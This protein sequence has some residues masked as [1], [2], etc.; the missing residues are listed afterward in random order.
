MRGA[1][2]DKYEPLEA[3]PRLQAFKHQLAVSIVKVIWL[4]KPP[5]APQI[6]LGLPLGGEITSPR[7]P[8]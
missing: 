8:T 6:T 1:G 5:K 3:A 7:P 4:E 2:E